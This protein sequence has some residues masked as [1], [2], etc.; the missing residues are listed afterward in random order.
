MEV[1][2]RCAAIAFFTAMRIVGI[3]SAGSSSMAMMSS[4]VL[5]LAERLPDLLVALERGELAGRQGSLALRGL[6]LLDLRA[7]DSHLEVQL[8]GMRVDTD[9]RMMTRSGPGS[10]RYREASDTLSIHSCNS[11]HPAATRHRGVARPVPMSAARGPKWSQP[12]A[13]MGYRNPRRRSML[14]PSRRTSTG[15]G[16]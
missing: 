2:G 5:S 13:R 15:E 12:G 14:R 9:T 16:G 3:F 11:R 6:Q 7:A 4:S 8:L 1:P 10:N